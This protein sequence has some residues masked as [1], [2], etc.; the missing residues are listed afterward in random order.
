M[1]YIIANNQI[2]YYK[3]EK[4]ANLVPVKKKLLKIN[5]SSLVFNLIH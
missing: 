4:Q 5:E 3:R 1:I 2:Q